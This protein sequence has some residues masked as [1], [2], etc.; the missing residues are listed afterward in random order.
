LTEESSAGRRIPEL[1][2]ATGAPPESVKSHV[3][4]NP[5]LV[6]VEAAQRA[7]TKQWIQKKREQLLEWLEA[8]HKKHPSATG[9]PIAAARLGLDA[10]L[11]NA[12]FD[13][14]SEIRIQ[15]EMIALA[16]H[17]AQFTDQ[18][19]RALSSMEQ[20]FRIAAL[21]PPLLTEAMK[22]SGLD[23]KAS[24]SLVEILIKSQR[25][26]R[27]S[28]DLV[29][30]ADAISQIR[31]SLSV[32]KGR[33]FSV[34]EFKDWMQVSRKYAIPLL[35]YLDRQRVTRRDGDSRVVL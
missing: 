4:Q 11:A 26:I 35:E 1:I 23:A 18:E 25:L 29:F 24:R 34:P 6:Y 12:V 9:A 10:S 32:H 30:H 13:G 15:G 20:V 16:G 22:A 33:R 5:R 28:E 7:V 31:K 17:Q 14:M 3:L 8:F 27:V 21:Q 2:S 19:A